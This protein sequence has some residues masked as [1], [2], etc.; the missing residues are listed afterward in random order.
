MINIKGFLSILL[1]N[2]EILSYKVDDINFYD[3]YNTLYNYL[4]YF[5]NFNVEETLIKNQSFL[6]IYQKGLSLKVYVL[7]MMKII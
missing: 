3:K 5:F 6:K 7:P 4:N 1:I 2:Y